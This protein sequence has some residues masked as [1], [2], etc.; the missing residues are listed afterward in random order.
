MGAPLGGIDFEAVLKRDYMLNCGVRESFSFRGT[1]GSHAAAAAAAAAT[2][3]AAAAAAGMYDTRII[4]VL[5]MYYTCI[6]TC[7]IRALDV[8]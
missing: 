3:A 4:H 5:Y 7:K 2:A 1:E 8:Y 6:H